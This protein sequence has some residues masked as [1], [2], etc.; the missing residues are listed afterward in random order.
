MLTLYFYPNACSMASHVA[1][2]EAGAA[3]EVK[4]INIFTGQQFTPE[5]KAINPRSKVPALRF[6]D[7]RVLLESTAILGWIGTA[8]PAANLLG[9]DPLAKARTIATCAW[10][11]GTVHP[12]FKQFY[13][14]EH[15]ISDAGLHAAVKEQAKLNYWAHLQEIDTILADRL[16]MMGEQFTVADA[17]ALVFYSWGRDLALPINELGNVVAMKDRLIQRPAARRALERE[18][19]VLLSM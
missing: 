4:K 11:S 6:D 19:S 12:T 2:E 10:L 16:W 17:Y 14:P 15:V 5:Y 9:G 7:G 18:K 8:F 13:H 1:L 3:F